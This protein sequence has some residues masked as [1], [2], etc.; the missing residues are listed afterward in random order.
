MLYILL[1]SVTHVATVP[2]AVTLRLMW[3][4]VYLNRNPVDSLKLS[5][6][7]LMKL[8]IGNRILSK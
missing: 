3:S 8:H 4:L 6:V 7:R 1:G 5:H 2:I